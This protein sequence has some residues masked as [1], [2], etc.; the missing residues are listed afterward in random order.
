MKRSRLIQLAVLGSAPLLLTGCEEERA[1]F[2]Y[3][4]LDACISANQLPAQVCR[5]D[6]SRAA[7]QHQQTAPRYVSASDCEADFGAARCESGSGSSSGFFVPLMTGYMIAS[8]LRGGQD[9]TG[10]QN[11]RSPQP[12]YRTRG[13]SSWRTSGN[14]LIGSNTGA[15]KVPARASEPA[16]R[17]VTMSR[18]G[19]GSTASARGSWGG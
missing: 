17:A 14:I 19:F 5:D 12:L 8:M 6:F 18:A 13:S 4:S 3:E 15:A 2:V 1:A 10:N 9:W 16:A 11:S 7:A